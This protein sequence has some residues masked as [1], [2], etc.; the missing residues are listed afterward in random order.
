MA[1]D[2]LSLDSSVV[3]DTADTQVECN[4]VGVKAGRS[5]TT[6]Q[7]LDGLLLVSGNDAANTLAHCWAGRTRPW[8]RSTPRL[9]R[10][11]R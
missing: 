8:P 2:E 7:L 6:R 10:W 9:R 4:C 11:A 5:Y 3:A 1:L